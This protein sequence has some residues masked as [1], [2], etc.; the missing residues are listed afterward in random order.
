MAT[1][2][3][4]GQGT[5]RPAAQAEVKVEGTCTV[6]RQDSHGYRT[7]SSVLHGLLISSRGPWKEQKQID[8]LT[9]GGP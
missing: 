4:W 8:H 7:L 1:A 2:G 9:D 5:G 3:S 6:L